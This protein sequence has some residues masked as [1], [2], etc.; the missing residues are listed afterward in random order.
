MVSLRCP[1][2]AR[3]AIPRAPQLPQV[4]G[5]TGK[6]LTLQD[7]SC[8]LELGGCEDG[9]RVGLEPK[10]WTQ[11]LLAS[12]PQVPEKVG[13][14]WASGWTVLPCLAP[15]VPLNAHPRC[16]CRALRPALPSFQSRFPSPFSKPHRLVEPGFRPSAAPRLGS[17]L[18]APWFWVAAG[19]L[20]APR[21]AQDPEQG[22]P[23][24]H[25]GA[26]R[27]PPGPG[28]HVR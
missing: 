16:W 1:A 27:P 12:E 26:G 14:T 24:P 2:E 17:V 19:P 7:G 5:R 20:G 6:M 8:S 15:W 22:P 23:P 13:V 18:S 21:A 11:T 10:L 25:C 28:W 9:G 3:L 4:V